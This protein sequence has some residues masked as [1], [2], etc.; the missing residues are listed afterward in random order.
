M[1]QNTLGAWIF[2][3][4][5]EAL[6]IEDLQ[7][8]LIQHGYEVVGTAGSGQDAIDGIKRTAPDVVIM[9]VRIAGELNGIEV[10]II[11]Q[12]HFDYVLPVIFL[13]G[14]SEGTFSYLKILPDYLY[15]NKPFKESVLIQAVERA[16][17]K[18]KQPL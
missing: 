15:I 2:L 5:D 7:R 1:E 11:A 16:L 18:G 8:R 3:V 10:A 12:S 4:E 14:F 6:V 9:D 17:K 13:T